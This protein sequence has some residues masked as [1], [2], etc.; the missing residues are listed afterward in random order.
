MQQR[1]AGGC[2][3]CHLEKMDVISEIRLRQSMRIYFNS[4]SVTFHADLISNDGAVEEY[5]PNRKQ[6]N[7]NTKMSSDM[8]SVPDPTFN[9]KKNKKPCTIFSM[10]S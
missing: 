8:G 10:Y 5:R 6:R 3:G 1:A 7:K 2:H 4:N 9:I